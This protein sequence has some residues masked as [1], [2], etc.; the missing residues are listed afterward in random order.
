[1][2]RPLKSPVASAIVLAIPLSLALW[3]ILGLV[4]AALRGVR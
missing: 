3:G 4:A 2:T 1:M